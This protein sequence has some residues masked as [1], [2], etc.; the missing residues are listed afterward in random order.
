MPAVPFPETHISGTPYGSMYPSQCKEQFSIAYI[1]AITTAARCKLENIEVDDESIDATI[2]Q[3]AKHA[4]IDF[5]S[6][7]VQLNCTSQAVER[8]GYVAWP[9]G[10]KNYSELITERRTGHII[11]IVLQVPEYFG[12]WLL[13][14]EGGLTMVK[15]AYWV[16]IRGLPE[17]PHGQTTK[18]VKL[19][20]IQ[21]FNV[22][23][24]LGILSR[25]GDGGAP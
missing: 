13:Q 21:P 1:H 25:V 6:L 24:L 8:Q 5:V 19:P 7:D 4:E 15:S 11:L 12:D 17:L 10:N 16:S 2:K 20:K 14:D 22:E 23:Q 3:V 18:T 9:L